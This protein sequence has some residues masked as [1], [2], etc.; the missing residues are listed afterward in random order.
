MKKL[1]TFY[2][3]VGFFIIVYLVYYNLCFLLFI[4]EIFEIFIYQLTLILYYSVTFLDTLIR[5]ISDK[6][7]SDPKYARIIGLIII[8]TP[9]ILILAFYENKFIIT[10]YI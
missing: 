3:K 8:L 1:K 5:P 6:K 9:F 2:R 4:S 7:E 10:R